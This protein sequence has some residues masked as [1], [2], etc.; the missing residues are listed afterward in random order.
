MI[1]FGI[2]QFNK[3]SFFKQVKTDFSYYTPKFKKL[4]TLRRISSLKIKNIRYET[5]QNKVKQQHWSIYSKTELYK[6]IVKINK[7]KSE[8]CFIFSRQTII[9]KLNLV[10]K[11]VLRT[12]QG[13]RSIFYD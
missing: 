9:I 5:K 12:I 13:V 3:I 10:V 6:K 8:H 4:T 11:Q 7:H 2:I 1:K